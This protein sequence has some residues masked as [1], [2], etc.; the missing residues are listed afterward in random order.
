MNDASSVSILTDSLSVQFSWTGDRFA[1]RIERS[2]GSEATIV[3][4][5]VQSSE[6]APAFQELHEQSGNDGE[7]V[8]FLSGAGGGAHWSM[9]VRAEGDAIEFDVAARV[10]QPPPNRVI[11]YLLESGWQASIRFVSESGAQI[12]S[13]EQ[14]GP[15]RLL[16][17][18][19]SADSLPRTLRW[20]FRIAAVEGNP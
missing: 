11:E 2:L 18:S 15:I 17:E 3:G 19:S 12:A 4:Q 16:P 14:A 6:Y 10:T 1:Q 13:D 20:K 5:S 9:S 7:L 8:I